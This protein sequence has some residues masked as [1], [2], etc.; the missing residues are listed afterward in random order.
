MFSPLR[1]PHPQSQRPSSDSN[2]VSRKTIS[3]C[4]TDMYQPGFTNAGM[5]GGQK[6]KE[7]RR[8]NLWYHLS[9]FHTLCWLR[10]QFR[11]IC[12]RYAAPEVTPQGFQ[13]I[14][15]LIRL[16]SLILSRVILR[17]YSLV[18]WLV[19]YDLSFW[20]HLVLFVGLIVKVI[21]SWLK[22]ML[23]HRMVALSEGYTNMTNGDHYGSTHIVG[24]CCEIP[25]TVTWRLIYSYNSPKLMGVGL[26][27]SKLRCPLILLRVSVL[28][29]D[30]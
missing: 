24:L 5:E 26:S 17:Q 13:F 29:I 4:N 1:S 23:Q 7:E 9:L 28:K 14:L 6:S 12:P 21:L 30:F 20:S 18:T 8:C 2:K 19:A 27:Y 22:C 25:A 15:D 10:S 16:T 11:D 3:H